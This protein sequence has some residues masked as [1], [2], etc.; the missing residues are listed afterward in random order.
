MNFWVKVL[1]I[2]LHLIVNSAL[3][4]QC[5]RKT[6]EALLD[7][8]L[9]TEG[10]YNQYTKEFNKV[11]A[12]Y[13]SQTLLSR[14]FTEKQMVTIWAKYKERFN[15]QLNN[16]MEATYHISKELLKRADIVSTDLKHVH[17][18]ARSWQDVADHCAIV[19]LPTQSKNALTHVESS[20]SLA[21]DIQ[22]LNKKF[23]VLSS[24]YRQEATMIDQ[25]LHTY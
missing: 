9:E 13:E 19:K 5:D 3:A 21:D 23:R 1:I 18:L 16:H 25:A 6:W 17:S 11:L 10:R 24:K 4:S 20:Q 2:S 7:Q 14:H 12:N 8:Q 22:T 15:T